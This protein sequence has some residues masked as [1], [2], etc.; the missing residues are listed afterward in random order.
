MDS[1]ILNIFMVVICENNS[2]KVVQ[3]LYRNSISSSTDFGDG[4]YCKSL[5]DAEALR[6]LVIERT[7]YKADNIKILKQST[8]EELI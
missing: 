6:R 8:T 4:I 1:P 7:D 2:R 3:A 5:E